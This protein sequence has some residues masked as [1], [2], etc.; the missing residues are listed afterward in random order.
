MKLSKAASNYTVMLSLI[1][2][3]CKKACGSQK[4]ICCYLFTCCECH[5]NRGAVYLTYEWHTGAEKI[6]YSHFLLLKVYL[7]VTQCYSG[8][9]AFEDI[10]FTKNWYMKINQMQLKRDYTFPIQVVYC[11]LLSKLTFYL[12]RYL[13]IY[14]CIIPFVVNS[15]FKCCNHS[16][17]NFAVL[18][19]AISYLSCDY[20]DMCKSYYRLSNFN[21][22]KCQSIA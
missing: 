19:A 3:I 6:I 18:E 17:K 5:R 1:A 12:I 11:S 10:V 4:V 22:K 20:F 8:A 2:F 7:N 13:F 9:F 21:Y 15:A 16:M 14:V